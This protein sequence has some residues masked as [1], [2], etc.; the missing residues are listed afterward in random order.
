MDPTHGS[1][2][3]AG[4]VRL[5]AGVLVTLA[6]LGA[7]LIAV[8]LSDAGGSVLLQTLGADGDRP[9][10]LVAAAMAGVVS[11][12]GVALWLPPMRDPSVNG[13]AKAGAAVV[14]VLI[15]VPGV[16]VAA[17]LAYAVAGLVA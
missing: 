15:A 5:G 7:A 6:G 12:A 13:G 1:G 4:A 16:F 14:G 3:V 2:G 8:S 11:L 9:R 10:A 17:A